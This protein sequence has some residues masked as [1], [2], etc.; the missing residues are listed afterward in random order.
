MG[1]K[2]GGEVYA[3]TH[4]H[5]ADHK[6]FDSIKEMLRTKVVTIAVKNKAGKVDTVTK[7]LIDILR[8][9]CPAGLEIYGENMTAIHSIDYTGYIS[10]YFYVFAV[11]LSGEW[12]SWDDT[13][14]VAKKLDLPMVPIRYR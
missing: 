10:H 11:K 8:Q 3:R 5:P 6:S 2:D 12:L 14:K 7:P 9:D 13:V 1:I 4:S